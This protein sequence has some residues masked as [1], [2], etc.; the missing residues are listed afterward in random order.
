[1]PMTAFSGVRSSWLIVARKSLFVRAAASAASRACATSKRR[2]ISSA[3]ASDTPDAVLDDEPEE[4][5]HRDAAEEAEARPEEEQARA[6]GARS[7][8][9]NTVFADGPSRARRPRNDPTPMT[10]AMTTGPSSVAVGCAKS[11]MR[12]DQASPSIPS[13]TR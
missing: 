10:A 12:S 1:M 2:R 11:K 4:E 6:P 7:V 13:A 9:A 8:T 5:R 3:V